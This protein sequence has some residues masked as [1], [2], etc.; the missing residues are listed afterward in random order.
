MLRPRF[1]PMLVTIK[2]AKNLNKLTM[3]ELH[4]YLCTYEVGF[5]NDKSTRK[6]ATFKASKKHEGLDFDN[7]LDLELANFVIIERF[8]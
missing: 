1:D 7:E 8:R 2:E 6:E 5:D 3:D 4:G